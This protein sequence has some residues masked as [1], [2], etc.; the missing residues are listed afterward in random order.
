MSSI[1]GNFRVSVPF[2]NIEEEVLESDI[3]TEEKICGVR[4]EQVLAFLRK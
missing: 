2:A 3:S 4:D 1:E